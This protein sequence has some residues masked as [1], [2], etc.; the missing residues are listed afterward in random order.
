MIPARII[1]VLSAALVLFLLLLGASVLIGRTYAAGKESREMSMRVSTEG[2]TYDQY[3][4]RQAE[5]LT[6]LLSGLPARALDVPA[7]VEMSREEIRSVE[8][9][10]RLRGVPLQVGLVKRLTPQVD[11]DGL[12]AA[13]RGA[14][15]PAK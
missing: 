5:M 3:R 8:Q 12:Q 14:G 7:R 4:Q 6:R 2:M 10:P 1:R 11:V 15:G 9:A 13:R